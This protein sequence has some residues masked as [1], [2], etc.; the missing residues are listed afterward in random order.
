[1]S[2]RGLHIEH[3][4]NLRNVDISP[5]PSINLITGDNAAGKTS[6]LEAIYC[7]S[8][9]RSFRGTS[10]DQLISHESDGF[11]LRGLIE[12]GGNDPRPIV[13]RRLGGHTELRVDAQ[14]V[15]SLS[16]VSTLLP[17]QVLNTESQRLLTD[18]PETR[19]ALLNWGV[20]HV[21]P[22]FGDVWRH[23]RR[24]LRQRNAALR[25]GLLREAA[26]WEPQLA[27]L[28]D[29][30]DRLRH[31]YVDR[32]IPV[33]KQLAAA[34]L[35]T[36]SLTWRYTRGWT[37]ER[38]LE[39]I[40]SDRRDQ[41]LDLGYTLSGPHRAD[42]RLLAHGRDAHHSLSRGQQKLAVIALRLAQMQVLRSGVGRTPTL[43]VDDLPAELDQTHR[44]AVLNALFENGAQLFLTAI[45]RSDLNRLPDA[46]RVFHVEQ[47]RYREVV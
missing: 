32:L 25:T 5:S 14:E 18:G 12:C 26:A 13:V 29:K 35:P 47:G 45:Q 44:A 28:G 7:L 37:H 42:L 30:I 39:T 17:V 36:E 3:F 20:F 33:W 6:L 2:L 19:R 38:S 24:A 22:G 40:L 9:A 27:D 43:L 4:R 15:R 10:I 41:E 16:A 11:L 46:T 23:Y 31:S 34:W 21:E 1:M 8:T